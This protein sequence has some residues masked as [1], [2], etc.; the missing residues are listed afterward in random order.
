MKL[1]VPL[2]VDFGM[3]GMAKSQT[4]LS[5]RS[6]FVGQQIRVIRWRYGGTHLSNY[7]PRAP[8]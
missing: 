6:H 2:C 1:V 4:L 3:I 5:R 7:T 8:R